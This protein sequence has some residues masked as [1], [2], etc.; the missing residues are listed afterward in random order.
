MSGSCDPDGQV[1]HDEMAQRIDRCCLRGR[2]L[3]RTAIDRI[4]GACCRR[5]SGY[6]RV[7]GCG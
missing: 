6:H 4:D 3:A 2:L 7:A 1:T 5:V